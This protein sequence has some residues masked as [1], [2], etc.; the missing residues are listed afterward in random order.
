MEGCRRRLI[1]GSVPTIWKIEPGKQTTTPQGKPCLILSI[2][3][4]IVSA[5][6]VSFS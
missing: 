5:M 4:S 2:S 6:K 3:F 1:P